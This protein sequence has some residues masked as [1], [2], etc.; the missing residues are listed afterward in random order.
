MLLFTGFL[1]KTSV[2][3]FTQ[4]TKK[5]NLRNYLLTLSLSKR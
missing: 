5:H 4:I 2:F 3:P 1:E